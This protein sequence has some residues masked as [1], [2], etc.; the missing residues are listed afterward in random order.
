M[1]GMLRIQGSLRHVEP[2]GRVQRVRVRRGHVAE[3][4]VRVLAHAHELPHRRARALRRGDV[5]HDPPRHVHGDQRIAVDVG[6][7]RQHHRLGLLGRGCRRLRRRLGRGLRLR[8]NLLGGLL[9]LRLLPPCRT[10]RAGRRGHHY[11]N[12][13]K[14][15]PLLHLSISDRYAN[16]AQHSTNLLRAQPSQRNQNDRRLHATPNAAVEWALAADPHVAAGGAVVAAVLADQGGV[17]AL[18]ALG[19]CHDAA[20]AAP[21]RGAS[22]MPICCTG[23]PSS[24]R[25]PSIA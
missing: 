22:R 5:G 15:L 2:G 10:R 14:P 1:S 18:G 11:G 19:A 6:L 21:W 12:G 23:R 3:L 8:R 7:G 17:G 9:D 16:A 20:L 4:G 24:S 25:M 13:G